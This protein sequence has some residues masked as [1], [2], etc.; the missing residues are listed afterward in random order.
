[1]ALRVKPVDDHFFAAFCDHTLCVRVRGILADVGQSQGAFVGE[2]ARWG[3]GRLVAGLCLLLLAADARADDTLMFCSP[4]TATETLSATRLEARMK[5][6]RVV[7]D[8]RKDCVARR[9]GR[10]RGWFEQRGAG[11]TLRLVAPDG[12]DYRA[13]LP[14][15]ARTDAALS[16]L[17]LAGRLGALAV[18][19]ESLVAEHGLRL[20][21]ARRA[22]PDA[23]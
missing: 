14:H 16:R 3:L 11:V 5:T 10:F 15:L 19:I 21:A 7:L 20:R 8:S 13:E 6:I 22:P 12:A 1:M 4:A 23:R 18:A 17:A 2:V 9:D